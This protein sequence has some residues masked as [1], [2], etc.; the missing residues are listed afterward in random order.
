MQNKKNDCETDASGT[1]S[2]GCLASDKTTTDTINVQGEKN[3]VDLD[4]GAK[5]KIDC[6]GEGSATNSVLCK[7]LVDRDI[8]EINITPIIEISTCCLRIDRPHIF[9]I[10]IMQIC[11]SKYYSHQIVCVYLYFKA[12]KVLV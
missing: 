11:G 10:F 3:K 12:H 8:G 9:F 2:E 6:E 1:S 7:A 4:F 5:Q